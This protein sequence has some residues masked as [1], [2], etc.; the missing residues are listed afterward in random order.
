[1]TVLQALILGI[2]QGLTEFLPV[3]SSAHL[4]FVPALMRIPSSVPFDTLLHLGTLLAVIGYFGKDVAA[5]VKAFF[6][7]LAD[8]PGKRFGRGLREDPFKRLAWLLIIGSIPAGVLGYFLKRFFE[9]LFHSVAATALLLIVTGIIL[10]FADRA[11]RGNKTASDLTLADGLAI[12]LAQAAAIAPGI[13]RSGAT[14]SAG[15]FLGLE[16]RAAAR[17]S[18]LLSIP[19]ILGATVLQLKGISAGFHLSA[20]VFLAGLISSFVCGLLAIRFMMKVIQERPL[21]VF[22]CYCWLAGGVF[23]ALSLLHVI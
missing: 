2:V 8:I 12:G 14:I 19:A 17:F 5:L 4:V 1:M 6:L 21:T 9:S 23:L 7:S 18:F 10:W 11:R 15:L 13:S 20:G 3:S 22:A 16:G